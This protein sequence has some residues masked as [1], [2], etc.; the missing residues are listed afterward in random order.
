LNVFKINK[1]KKTILVTIDDNVSKKTKIKKFEQLGVK[2]IFVK[3]NHNGR[4]H[5]KSALKALRKVGIASIL[6][7]GGAKIYSSFVKQDLFDDVL[8]FISPKI[9]GI[10]IK[11]FSELSS[12]NL[13]DALKLKLESSDIF[14]DDILLHFVK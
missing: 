9:L 3:K 6:V 2:L 14:G 4:V 13:K 11:T 12:T 10:G 7:E 8:M 1:D 5:L